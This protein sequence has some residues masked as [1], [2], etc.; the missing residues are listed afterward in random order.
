MWTQDDHGAWFAQV[1]YRPAGSHSRVIGAFSA[2]SVR[3]HHRPLTRTVLTS[4]RGPWCA[5]QQ[6]PRPGAEHKPMR[7]L[8]TGLAGSEARSVARRAFYAHKRRKDAQLNRAECVSSGYHS[9]TLRCVDVDYRSANVEGFELG[10]FASYDDCGDAWVRAPD[11]SEATLIWETGDPAYFQV[12]IEPNESRWG[13]YAVQLPL[14]LTSDEEAASYLDGLL[15]ELRPG[16]KHGGADGQT[17]APDQPVI[18]MCGCRAALRGDERPCN[19]CVVWLANC[20]Q[21]GRVRRRYVARPKH[22]SPSEDQSL[23]SHRHL[24]CFLTT[25]S[26]KMPWPCRGSFLLVTGAVRHRFSVVSSGR[27]NV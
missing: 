1:Q 4:S 7:R 23:V 14:P 18:G 26:R 27:A 17:S 21:C 12:S 20:C 3:G 9:T 10:M 19:V 25:R 16:G 15:P 22:P 6:R 5:R 24:S 2:E 13:T 11:G 8:A